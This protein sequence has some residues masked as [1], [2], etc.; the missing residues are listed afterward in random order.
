MASS[1]DSEAA[2][3]AYRRQK[4]EVSKGSYIVT[5]TISVR[6]TDNERRTQEQRADQE[7]RTV[8]DYVRLL[9]E[10]AEQQGDCR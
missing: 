3:T 1:V 2:N 9:V 7:A 4:E 6:L 8:S 10:R 5:S